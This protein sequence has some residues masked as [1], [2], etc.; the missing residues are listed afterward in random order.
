[1]EILEKF[2]K[3]LRKKCPKKELGMILT[4]I[5]IVRGTSKDGSAV[6]EMRV[7]F[8]E[9]KLK[10]LINDYEKR[11]GICGIK[12]WINKGLLKVGDPIMVV[13]IAGRFRKDVLPCFEE[14]LTCIKNEV[15]KEEEK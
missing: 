10:A 15:V 8:S 1:M 5:G 14:L 11:E 4:H 9:V 6:E 3:E 12:V 2:I 13:A 7:D